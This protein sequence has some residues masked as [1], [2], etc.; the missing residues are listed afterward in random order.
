MF[1]IADRLLT[2]LDSG[3]D[4]AI[5]TVARVLGSAPR[6][7]GT[8][9]AFA[10]GRVLGSISGGCVEGAA[11]EAC[12]RVLLS[13]R[14]ETSRFGF[15]DD[16]AFAVGL[17]CGGELDI[18]VSRIG[19]PSVRAELEAARAGRP[20]GVATVVAGPESLVGVTLAAGEGRG[21]DGDLGSAALEEAG[22]TD[23]SLERISAQ[24]DSWFAAGRT[25]ELVIE[26]ESS[27][28]LFVETQ[29]PAP[30]LVIVGAVEFGAALAAAA[31]PLGYRLTV[32][33][34]RPAF[35]TPERFPA[36]HEV[37]VEWPHL[38]LAGLELDD[39]SVICVLSHDDRF[40]LPVLREALA[41]P[42]GYVGAMGSRRTHDRRMAAL[43]DAGVEEAALD[44]LHSPIGLDIGA[45]TPEETAISILAEVLAARSGAS[46]LSLSD[47]DGPIHI[48]R[49]VPPAED[50]Q[51]RRPAHPRREERTR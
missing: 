20:A 28:S 47:V 10:D 39:R 31:R 34:A 45:S 5:A 42:A 41:S 27:L 4:T 21:L 26:C 16:D 43:R 30:R 8:S 51:Q 40:D 3:A 37:V 15:S 49:D 25:G 13:G 35:A 46:R 14:A 36:A 24:I 9:M 48:R 2:A 17:S 29:R 11:V 12:E 50:R 33:D 32:C 44:R 6:T 19:S 18:V 7:I 22:V 38:Y 1:E 23:V